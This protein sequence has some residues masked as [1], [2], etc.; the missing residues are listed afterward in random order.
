MGSAALAGGMVALAAG[1]GVAIADIGAHQTDQTIIVV[2]GLLSQTVSI[3]CGLVGRRQYR[4][5]QES[6]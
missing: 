2:A 1:I 3:V 4:I 6:Q 5:R